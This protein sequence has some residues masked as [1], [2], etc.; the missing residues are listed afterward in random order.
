MNPQPRTRSDRSR[1]PGRAL[2]AVALFLNIAAVAAEETDLSYPPPGASAPLVDRA[3]GESNAGSVLTP[4]E[5]RERARLYRQGHLIIDADFNL[6]QPAPPAP[7]AEKP[8]AEPTP[9]ATTPPPP[10]AP[11]AKV[12]PRDGVALSAAT[13]KG[14][15]WKLERAGKPASFLFGTIHVED[16]RVT[17]LPRKVKQAFDASRSYT[18]EALL[19]QPEQAPLA[20]GM[21]FSDGRDLETVAGRELYAQTAR[22]LADYGIPA[23]AANAMKPW[24]AMLTLSY[25]K[26]K[27]GLFLDKSLYLAAKE[28]GK[29]VHGLETLAEQIAVFDELPM[30]DQVTLLRETVTNTKELPRMFED[31]TKAYLARD[32]TRLSAIADEYRPKDARLAREFMQRLLK[33]RNGHMLERMLPRLEEGHAFV[34]VGALHLAGPDGLLAQLK[35]RGYRVSPIY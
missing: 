33:D 18:M 20:M 11:E 24:A 19:D 35:N 27:T 1:R 29:T 28:K 10:E 12:N 15:L 16:P 26:P 6:I 8:A 21:L 25:P 30:D 4:A 7:P 31:M 23:R 14:L 13:Q 9:S 34:A 32:L 2:C 17:R 5:A 22:L 3:K